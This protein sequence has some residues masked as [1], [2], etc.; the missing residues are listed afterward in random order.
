MGDDFPVCAHLYL[1]DSIPV[2][3]KIIPLPTFQLNMNNY[4]SNL[5]L[6]HLSTASIQAITINV[7]EVNLFI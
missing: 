5:A 3:T 2:N 7:L 1:Q 6:M 4:I